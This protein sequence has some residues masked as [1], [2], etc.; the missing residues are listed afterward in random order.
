MLK[1]K[2][3]QVKLHSRFRAVQ[4]GCTGSGYKEIPWLNVSGIWLEQ[5]GFPVGDAVEITVEQ[6]T[7]LI[8]KCSANGTKEH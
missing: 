8:K 4:R 2:V 6:N 7:L 3:R 1:E 5:A